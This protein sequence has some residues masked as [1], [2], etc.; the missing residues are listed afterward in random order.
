MDVTPHVSIK[1]M[2]NTSSG[3][4]MKLTN[5]RG[6]NVGV[7]NDTAVELVFLSN[8]SVKTYNHSVILK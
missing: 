7:N 8:D 2:D 1:N 3:A 6:D 4:V 5:A